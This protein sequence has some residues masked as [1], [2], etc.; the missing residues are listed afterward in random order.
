VLIALTGFLE[1]ALRGAV[2][3]AEKLSLLIGGAGC[4]ARGGFRRALEEARRSK[5]YALIVEYK[6]CSPSEGL[7]AYHTPRY[8]AE[9]TLARVDAYSVLTEPFWFCGSIELIPLFS[10]YRPVLAKDIIASDEQLAA[11]ACMGA[12]AALIIDSDQVDLE[13]LAYKALDMGLDV[14]VET[15]SHERAARIADLIPEAVIGINSRNLSTLKV[16]FESML[17]E[18][19][20][21]REILGSRVILVAESGINSPSR[22]VRAVKSGADAL[23]IGTAI[24][25][26]PGLL[27]EIDAA[28]RKAMKGPGESR[29]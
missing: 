11:V 3:R 26:D 10:Q 9:A 22:A 19:R 23:L 15:V 21:A 1:E 24:M 7:I 25:R 13:H 18:L 4:R 28:L 27:E 16:D 8:Y 14:L 2:E 17:R 20:A 6:R 29:P 5:G 12:S